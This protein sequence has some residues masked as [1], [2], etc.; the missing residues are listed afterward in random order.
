MQQ[1]INA[2][3][4]GIHMMNPYDYNDSATIMTYHRGAYF[5]SS[6]TK[7]SFTFRLSIGRFG[8]STSPLSQVEPFPLMNVVI[9][10]GHYHPH[11]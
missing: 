3:V 7:T 6:W 9:L 10:T 2:D 1:R 8:S 5:L 4:Q 11:S